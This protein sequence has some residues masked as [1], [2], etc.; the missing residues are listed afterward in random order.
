MAIFVLS[1]TMKQFLTFHPTI[2]LEEQKAQTPLISTLI[3]M[4]NIEA[5]QQGL[6]SLSCFLFILMAALL[7]EVPYFLIRTRQLRVTP[8]HAIAI[9]PGS[10]G[11]NKYLTLTWT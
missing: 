3:P 4:G 8:I 1:C 6:E 7:Q 10:A 2:V 11:I 9:R 5:P